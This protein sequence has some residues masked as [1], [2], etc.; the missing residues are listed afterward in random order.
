MPD[1]Y[2]DKYVLC[3]YYHTNENRKIKCDG[4]TEWNQIVNTKKRGFPSF[5][6]LWGYSI[7]L[8]NFV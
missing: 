7:F 6:Y 4:E 3:P 8:C 1:K 2:D 5:L